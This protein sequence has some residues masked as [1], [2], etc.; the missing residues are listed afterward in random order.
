MPPRCG[1]S[2]DKLRERPGPLPPRP[3]VKFPLCTLAE[4]PRTAAHCIEYAPLS[5]GGPDRA[6]EAFDADNPEHLKWVFEQARAPHRV[7]QSRSHR[8]AR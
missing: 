7:E 8:G 5:P 3:Q 2:R 1:G 6:G 4:T